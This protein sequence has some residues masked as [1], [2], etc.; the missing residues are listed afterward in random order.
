MTTSTINSS[1]SSAI[2]F[3]EANVQN[4]A[5]YGLSFFE[6]REDR[7]QF[8]LGKKLVSTSGKA[9]VGSVKVTKVSTAV[10]TDDSVLDA[11]LS[12]YYSGSSLDG[13]YKSV[14]G[15][16]CF[17]L[18]VQAPWAH[19]RAS[20]IARVGRRF[21]SATSKTFDAVCPDLRAVGANWVGR[22]A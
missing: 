13:N 11:I 12:V 10:V 17:L 3:F 16:L 9:P 7:A 5:N 15:T 1:N 14:W 6:S 19:F 20:Q 18:N 2:A 8:N 21:E 22:V 4:V